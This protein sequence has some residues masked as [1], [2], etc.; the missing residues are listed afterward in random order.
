MHLDCLE[1]RESD[2]GS[3]GSFDPV[4]ADALV[5]SSLESLRLKHV[6]QSVPDWRVD[7]IHA[8]Y[9]CKIAHDT[10]V[11]RR[12]NSN[13][14]IVPSVL[15]RCWLG[16]RNSIRAVKNW[17]MRRCRGGGT[18]D[19]LRRVP[20]Q[21]LAWRGTSFCH[22]ISIHRPTGVYCHLWRGSVN[23]RNIITDKENAGIFSCDVGFFL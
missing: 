6:D 7:V 5:Q 11:I 15:R 16:V 22:S 19:A 18:I 12:P 21:N 9:S 8:S 14:W 23:L 3:D 2:G 17:V 4:E 1:C 13:S 20:H 10:L